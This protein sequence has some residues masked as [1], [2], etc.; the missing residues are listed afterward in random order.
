MAIA[1]QAGIPIITVPNFSGWA[2]KLSNTFMDDRKR[3]KCIEAKT[4]EEA[5]NKALESVNV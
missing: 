3:I 4:P 5:L 2:G 1:Y